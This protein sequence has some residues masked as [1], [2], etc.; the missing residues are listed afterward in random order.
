MGAQ[1]RS[2]QARARKVALSK[3]VSMTTVKGNFCPEKLPMCLPRDVHLGM[4]DNHE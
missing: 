4:K 2:T 3:S 1:A